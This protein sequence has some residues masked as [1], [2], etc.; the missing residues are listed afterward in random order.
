MMQTA[1]LLPRRR[2]SMTRPS[3]SGLCRAL[4]GF[5]VSRSIGQISTLDLRVAEVEELDIR[6]QGNK[7][8]EYRARVQASFRYH[9]RKA[10]ISD[11]SEQALNRCSLDCAL[12]A[13]PRRIH[14]SAA[15]AATVVPVANQIRL[16][17]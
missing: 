4:R 7:V 16:Y 2:R 3:A 17:W 14:G 13:P 1:A 6:M 11:K 10:L 9:P 5:A 8:V 12:P 15:G